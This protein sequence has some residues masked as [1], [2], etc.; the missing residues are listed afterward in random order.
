M[1][2]LIQELRSKLSD[3]ET[4]HP[5]LCHDF[6]A[7]CDD[8]MSRLNSTISLQATPSKHHSEDAIFANRGEEQRHPDD[9]PDAL[10][11]VNKNS[12]LYTNPVSRAF[13]TAG[14]HIITGLDKMGDGVIILFESLL[15]L[16]NPKSGKRNTAVKNK[17]PT[18]I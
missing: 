2:L 15:K 17:V 18:V 4:Q 14:E 1:L 3:I 8:A 5:T 9:L 16:G 6:T 10:A 11:P 13:D 12:H 7:L